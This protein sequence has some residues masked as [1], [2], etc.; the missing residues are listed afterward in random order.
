MNFLTKYPARSGFLLITIF[1]L[2]SVVFIFEYAQKERA[3]DLMDWQL[4]LSIL[5]DIRAASI[6]EWL[7]D[8]KN[9]LHELA[10]NPSLELYLSQYRQYDSKD[11]A[12]QA[13]LAHV[14]NLLQA[15]SLRFGFSNKKLN[16]INTEQQTKQQQGLAILSDTGELLFSTGGF[17]ND[18]SQHKQQI[19]TVLMTGQ[20]T[21]LDIF[22]VDNKRVLYG[23]VLPVYPIQK[24]QKQQA[25]GAVIVLLDPA[26][27]LYKRLKNVHVNTK[28]DE[29]VLVRKA[30]LAIEF[31]SPLQGG[32]K[33]LYKRPLKNMHTVFTQQANLI[34]RNDYRNKKVLS[35]SRSITSTPWVLIQKIDADE[36]LQE[37]DDHQQY[38]FSTFFL[39]SLLIMSV[40]IAVWRHGTSVRLLKISQNLETRTALLNAVSDNINEPIFLVDKQKKFVFINYSLAKSMQL[41]AQSIYGKK[42]P[43]V[44][45]VQGAKKL[46]RISDEQ[47]KLDAEHVVTLTLGEKE[48]IYHVSSVDLQRGEYKNGRLF[49]LHDITVLR[50][51]Q[52]KRDRLSRGIIST[53]VKAV[54]LHDPYC[55]DHSARTKEVALDIAHELGLKKL[56]CETLEMAALLANIGKLFVSKEILT[57]MGVLTEEESRALRKNIPYAVNILKELAFEGPVV[58]IIAQKNES[59]DGSGY[60][61]GLKDEAIMLEARILAVSNAFVAMA[62]SRAYRQG[63]PIKEVINIL[64][65]QADIRYDRRVVAALFH[66]AEN[67]KDWDKWQNVAQ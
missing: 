58:E 6:E 22:K 44:L 48:S 54:D 59:L 21:M 5:A 34:I 64:L 1:I 65:Q 14:K 7:A 47:N 13:Q 35:L 51:A 41:D 57:K 36:A 60:P 56:A 9:K 28:T 49:V 37:S 63:R 24:T 55:M 42:M 27:N 18:L 43:S 26:K 20:G 53:L 67:K 11:I 61:E 25:V 39:I 10:N 66:I 62:S 38:L 30:G 16:S 31:L 3:R 46:Q 32:V 40:F 50:T 23:F 17:Y 19:E 33:I 15:T 4:R 52:Q 8:R 2:L 45:G 29:S 12:I